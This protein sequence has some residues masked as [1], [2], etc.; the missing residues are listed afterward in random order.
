M[1]RLKLLRLALMV[2]GIALARALTPL[3]KLASWMH[4]RLMVNRAAVQLL[5]ALIAQDQ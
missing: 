3:C 2:K 5:D 4:N 1:I